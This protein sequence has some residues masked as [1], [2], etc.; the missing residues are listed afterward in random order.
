[1]SYY[2][3]YD[4]VSPEP[5]WAII[6]EELRS[7]FESNSV[8]DV[9]FPAWTNRALKKLGKSSYKIEETV[10]RQC[11][12]ESKLPPDYYAVREAWLCTRPTTPFAYPGDTT[13]VNSFTEQPI[14][15]NI[16]ANEQASFNAV[17]QSPNSFYEQIFCKVTPEQNGC[18]EGCDDCQPDVLR[19]TYKGNTTKGVNTWNEWY[20]KVY[21]LKP[22]NI[23]VRANH[24]LFLR[25]MN[26][27]SA[28][29]YDIRDGKFV[30]NLREGAVYLVYYTKEL[31]E[32]GTELIP[33]NWWI[34]EYVKRYIKMKIFEQLFNQVTDETFN[35]VEKKY[36]MAKQSYEESWIMA[37]VEIKKQDVYQ[38]QRAIKR[39]ANRLRHY[40]IR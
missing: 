9:M 5:M 25:N 28:D 1:M 2:Y 6:K 35:Q 17:V 20:Q 23:T 8:D 22:G 40:H 24:G 27:S 33:D 11:E 30:T 13:I 36:E 26:S 39:D 10:L 18:V 34:Q 32:S 19:V 3:K 31:D 14:F 21:L 15:P 12:F 38:K 37:D 16:P 4:F 7:Y 29:S